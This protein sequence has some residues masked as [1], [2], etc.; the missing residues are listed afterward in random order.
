MERDAEIPNVRFIVKGLG[1]EVLES[2]DGG[3]TVVARLPADAGGRLPGA[4]AYLA[5]TL[6]E[7]LSI[8]SAN[9]AIRHSGFVVVRE[10]LLKAKKFFGACPTG[11]ALGY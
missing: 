2:E 4:L 11:R 10:A 8:S 1:G 9:R 3:L 7:G 6:P 5:S